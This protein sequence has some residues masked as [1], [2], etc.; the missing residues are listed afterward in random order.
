MMK[1]F[2]GK[3]S[4][5]GLLG[6]SGGGGSLLSFRPNLRFSSFQNDFD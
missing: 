6:N 3:V 4:R 5:D 1:E 2:K